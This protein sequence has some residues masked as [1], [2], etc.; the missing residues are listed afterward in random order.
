MDKFIIIMECEMYE[1]DYTK[2]Q[3]KNMVEENML[4]HIDGAPFGVNRVRIVD[5]S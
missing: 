4:N 2:E 5:P 1:E 3:V